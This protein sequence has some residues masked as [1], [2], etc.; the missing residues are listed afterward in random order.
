M[1]GNQASLQGKQIFLTEV[2]AASAKV[3]TGRAYIES[4]DNFLVNLDL[5]NPEWLPKFEGTTSFHVF[6]IWSLVPESP[7]RELEFWM[8]STIKT[9]N[10][11][12]I[13]LQE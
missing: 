1:S 9:S 2:I 3:V 5:N 11:M 4:L 10:L 12:E 7:R 6:S 8:T 13:R